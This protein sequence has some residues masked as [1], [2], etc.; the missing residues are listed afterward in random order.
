LNNPLQAIRGF[1]DLL[2]ESA[3]S[4]EDREALDTIAREARRAARIVSELRLVVRNSQEETG[5]RE[6]VDLNDVVRH[7]L[8]TRAY[9]LSSANIEVR[10]DLA[11]TLPLLSGDASKLEQVALNLV[12]NAAQALAD[13]PGARRMIVRTRRTRAG[14]SLAVYDNGP[15]IDPGHM[16]RLFD[17]FWTTKPA[18]KGTGL[19]LSVV[20]QIVTEHGGTVHVDSEPGRGTNFLIDLPLGV[21]PATPVAAPDGAPPVVADPVLRPLRILIVDDEE[22]L[23]RMLIRLGTRRGHAVDGAQEGGEALDLIRGAESAGL[24]YDL[25]LSDLHMP[26]MSGRLFTEQLLEH[27]ADYESRLVLL[28]GAVDTSD[29][30]WVREHTSVPILNK[31]FSLEDINRIIADAARQAS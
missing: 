22:P 29:I 9:S 25:I 17:P 27:D 24:P 21:D 16:P 20:H 19:G 26:G 15:G 5:P 14:C 2:A 28:T 8:R 10:L 1:A 11:G 6:A 4:E 31:P 13:V 23:R 30:A 7:V 12:V 18:G 3:R